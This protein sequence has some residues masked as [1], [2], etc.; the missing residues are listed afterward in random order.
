MGKYNKKTR[1]P[2]TK[3]TS[4]NAPKK[5]TRKKKKARANINQVLVAVETGDADAKRVLRILERLK[6]AKTESK[7]EA[8]LQKALCG[9][10]SED[11]KAAALAH[12]AGNGFTSC[13]RLLLEGRANTESCS[14]AQ[15]SRTPLQVAASRGH[16]EVCRL[17]VAAGA[18]RAGASEAAHELSHLGATFTE[19]RVRIREILQS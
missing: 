9:D 16:V 7:A 10:R 12:F 1:V 11:V 4:N 3:K 17:L 18:N 14:P 15:D 2:V 6:Q 13:V 19:E 8:A 5:Q